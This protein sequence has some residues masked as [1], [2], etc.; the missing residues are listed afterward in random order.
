MKT[1]NLLAVAISAK[2]HSLRVVCRWARRE[3]RFGP[4]TD[5]ISMPNPVAHA[6]RPL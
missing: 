2:G 4:K 6:S 3:V 5:P 1:R